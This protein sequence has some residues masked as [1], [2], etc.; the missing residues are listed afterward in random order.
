MGAIP[1][2]VDR[3]T[4]QKL[5]EKG[6]AST[7]RELKRWYREGITEEE[8]KAKKTTLIGSYKVRLATTGGLAGRILS[9]S[10]MGR[11]VNYLDQYP[12]DLEAI[13][14]EAVNAAIQ[15]YLNPDD[16]ITVMAGSV[17]QSEE[18]VE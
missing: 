6:L 9:F 12:K 5:L 3:K 16:M 11:R 10:Q 18:A 4:V 8:L 14:I 15:R 1:H 2:C 13:R 17:E 7:R